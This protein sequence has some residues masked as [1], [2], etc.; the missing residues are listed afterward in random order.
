M[1]RHLNAASLLV[2][3]YDE[4]IAFFT[5]KLGFTLTEDTDLGNGKR[6]VIVHPG[7]AASPAAGLLLAK[8]ANQAQQNCLGKQGADRVMFFLYTD[9]F[10][11]DY[12]SMT[13]AGVIFLEPP[14]EETYGKVCVFK[15]I[16]GNRWD[17][18]EPVN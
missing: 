3:N 4:A 9:N 8:P 14:R 7:D 2:R 5:E 17:L 15:D 13:E 12:R 1:K 6:W 18:L 16:S 11:R 10:N